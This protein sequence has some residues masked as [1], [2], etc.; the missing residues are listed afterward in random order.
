LQL[1]VSEPKAFDDDVYCLNV[2]DHDP[3][4]PMNQSRAQVGES[5]TVI[6]VERIRTSS[7]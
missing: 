7:I 4:K 5:V 2:R 3:Y 1:G 6:R